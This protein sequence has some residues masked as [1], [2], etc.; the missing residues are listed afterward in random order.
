M[1]IRARK[2]LFLLSVVVFGGLLF[3]G[4]RG[5][6]GFGRYPGPYGDLISA[7]VVPERHV[8]N[9]PTAINFDYRGLDTLGEEYILFTSVAALVLLLRYERE[10]TEL[11]THLNAPARLEDLR[12]EALQGMGPWLAA[13]I[14]VFGFYTVLHGALTPGGGF[15]GGV[16]AGTASLLV[17]LAVGAPAFHSLHSNP[18]LD[19][20]DAAG[21]G[22]YALVGM[23]T[24]L[25]GAL[26]LQNILPLGE[27]GGLTAGGTIPVINF[28]TCSSCSSDPSS[29]APS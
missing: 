27:T 21:A 1:S 7:G 25:T 8:T 10:V 4:F 11:S 28:A 14:A 12:G 9:A 18:L 6:P 20:F 17:Y 24:S 22:A 3:L 16:I 23:M 19:V 2:I 13:V 15:H 29:T 5:L 26:F